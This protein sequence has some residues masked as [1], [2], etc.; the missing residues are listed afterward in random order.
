MLSSDITCR[1]IV[2]SPS[3]R[4][5]APCLPNCISL[6]LEDAVGLLGS[7]LAGQQ[8][9]KGCTDDS[10]RYVAEVTYVLANEDCSV[11]LLP[12]VESGHEDEGEGEF[13][14]TDLGD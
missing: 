6:R 8:K 9:A 10:A 2:V 11:Y 14:L 7:R 1:R 3:V 12:E 5:L 13:P 4:K